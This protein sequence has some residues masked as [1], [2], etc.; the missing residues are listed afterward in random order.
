MNA[1][2]DIDK[3]VAALR[4]GALNA[5]VHEVE[6]WDYDDKGMTLGEDWTFTE[7]FTYEDDQD[8]KWTLISENHTVRYLHV[9][10]RNYERWDWDSYDEDHQIDDVMGEPVEGALTEEEFEALF[11][12][13]PSTYGAEGPMMNYWYDC[14]MLSDDPEAVAVKLL[15]TP[16]CVVKVHE[17]WGLALTGGGMDLTWEIVEAFVAID[18]LPPVH[19]ARSLPGMAG[20]GTSDKDRLLIAACQRSMHEAE[21]ILRR[22]RERLYDNAARWADGKV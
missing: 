3:T 5:Q 8:R 10:G 16:L 18:M 7:A 12:I 15:N 11:E 20:R 21:E 6:G 1:I 13:S 19:F 14:P 22:D 2:A 9:D 4:Y 17:E